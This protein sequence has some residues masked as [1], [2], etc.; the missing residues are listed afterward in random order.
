MQRWIVLGVA[1]V[2]LGIA[3][4]FG[5]RKA[6]RSHQNNQPGPVWVPIAVNPETPIER[7]D[8]VAATLKRALSTEAMLTGVVEDLGL[9]QTWGMASDEQAAR[10]LGR[11]LIVRTGTMD[12]PRGALPAIHIGVT[13]KIKE[14]PTSEAISMRLIKEVWPILGIQPPPER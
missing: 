1:V 11:R 8:E 4:L 13:G 6:W 5:A 10:E 12:T 3:G 2:L 7:Q 14:R 9:R